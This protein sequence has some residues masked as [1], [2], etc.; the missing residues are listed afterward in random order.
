MDDERNRT[1]PEPESDS[2]AHQVLPD[3]EG[4]PTPGAVEAVKKAEP[5]ADQEAEIDIVTKASMQSLPASDSPSWGPGP[6]EEEG[7]G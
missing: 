1:E 7:S 3:D 4:M 5:A 6:P 2:K